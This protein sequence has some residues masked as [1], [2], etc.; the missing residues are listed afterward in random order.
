MPL[1]TTGPLRPAL[2]RLTVVF[3]TAVAAL[4]GCQPAEQ[5]TKYTAPKDPPDLDQI[6]DEPAEGEPRVRVLGAIAPA[7][8]GGEES[9][10]FFKLQPAGMGQTY[11]P[12][13]VE[14]HKADFDAFVKSLKFPADGPPTWTLPPGWRT[15]EVKTQV[16]RL[17]TFRMKK[18]E[19]VVDLAVSETGG[20]LLTN[21]NRWRGQAGVDP[22]KQ[23]EIETKCQ[24]L[25][26]DGRKVVVVDVSGPGGKG[27]MMPPFAK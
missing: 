5:V 3:L 27:G 17:A 12:A 26:I 13:A 24:T 11:T 20:D 22:I 15:V 4:A 7:G 9:W 6:S 10:Y 21:I 23:D 8:K 2:R 25:M 14:R 18:S 16:P 19:T 1:R